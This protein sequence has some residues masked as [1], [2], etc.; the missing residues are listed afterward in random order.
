MILPTAK[1]V[2]TVREYVPLVG[3]LVVDTRVVDAGVVAT[4]HVGLAMSAE[5]D[6]VAETAAVVAVQVEFVVG[7]A[8]MK[9]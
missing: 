8:R 4:V 1:K 7:A 2:R 3:G 9:G 6:V 5:V